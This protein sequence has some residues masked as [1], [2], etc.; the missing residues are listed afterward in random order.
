MWW[1]LLAPAE[2]RE[3][4]E[5]WT[6][7]LKLE[8]KDKYMKA[9]LWRSQFQQPVVANLCRMLRDAGWVLGSEVESL[10]KSM[11]SG[12]GQTKVNEDANHYARLLE[13]HGSNEASG[14]MRL[15]Q[16]L[17]QKRVLGSV[18]RALFAHAFGLGGLVSLARFG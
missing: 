1:V 14:T 9:I 16:K 8:G 6:K 12:F 10:I 17:V 7:L 4:Y 2:V 13:T 11:F 5:N 15:W 3:S 18:P